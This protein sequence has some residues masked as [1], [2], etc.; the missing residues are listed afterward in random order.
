MIANTIM[1]NI[2]KAIVF[3]RSGIDL[4][5]ILTSL[6]ILGTLLKV[7]KGRNTLKALNILKLGTSSPKK[8]VIVIS[9]ILARTTKKSTKFQLFLR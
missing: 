7:L 1:K 8:K 4:N 9:K 3:P 5:I 6:R 2:V